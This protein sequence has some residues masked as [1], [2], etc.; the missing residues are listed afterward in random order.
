[1]HPS[2]TLRIAVAAALSA[3]SL[4]SALG[5][6][7]RLNRPLAVPS[8]QLGPRPFFLVNDMPEGELKQQL[9]DC[10]GTMQ[11]YRTS[12]FSLAHR[13]APMQFPEHTR[14][15]YEAGV[16][17]GAGIVECDVTFTRDKELV[18][19]H[20][21][22]DL[23]ATTN[24]LATPLASR[25][26]LPFQPAVFDGAGALVS[27][28]KAEC[29]TS[30]ITLAEYKT[31]RGKMDG[32]NVRG[33]TPQEYMDGTPGWRTDLYAGPT[34]GTLMTHA[35]SIALLQK[36]GVKMMPELK[37]P[38]VPMPFDGFSQQAFAQKL[39]DEYKAAGVPPSSV[40]PQSF[41]RDDVLYWVANEPAFGAQ[42]VYLDN[43]ATPADLPTAADLN[44]YKTQ[45][46]NIWAPPLW[47]LLALDAN[48]RIVASQAAKD[49][50][51]AGLSLITWSME[52]SGVLADGNNGAFYQTIA[53]AIS[54]EGDML[55]VIDVLA[56]EV[57]V[58]GLFSDWPAT[59]SFYANCKGK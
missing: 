17:M 38:V 57:G 16:R 24:I 51:A 12:D 40:Y 34:S 13:G 36:L 47:A 25:C 6:P 20:S 5:K 30:D 29:R 56:Q 58:I 55:R 32:V 33:R 3:A 44:A 10:A 49:A 35:E 7:M 46:I 48:N 11:H 41:R 15:S 37:L 59:V 27:P 14:E 39:L 42:A 18:C 53:P 31:L 21:Q 52:R 28:A 54:R 9:N 22:N 4:G 1:M 23:H 45:G 8:A 50:R 19:R 2:T 26:T 43:A